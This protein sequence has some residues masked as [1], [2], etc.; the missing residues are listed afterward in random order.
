MGMDVRVVLESSEGLGVL[1]CRLD[2]KKDTSGTLGVLKAVK[3]RV[4]V[5]RLAMHD[6]HTIFLVLIHE[7]GSSETFTEVCRRVER[8]W[9]LDVIGGS[10]PREVVETP[11]SSG[12]F[13]EYA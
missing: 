3:F 13:L 7:K 11:L 9:R 10:A 5:Q 1:R 4:E 2:Q 6:K 8:E 12:H